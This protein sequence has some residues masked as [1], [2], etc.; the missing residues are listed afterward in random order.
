MVY[1]DMNKLYDIVSRRREDNKR[2][3]MPEGNNRNL[4]HDLTYFISVLINTVKLIK[5][6]CMC[7]INKKTIISI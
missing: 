2:K 7:K 1:R 6:A 5:N 4:K 3:I